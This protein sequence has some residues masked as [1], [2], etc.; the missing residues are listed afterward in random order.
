M[1]ATITCLRERG[2]RRN[3]HQI[4]SDPGTAGDLILAM[5]GG[6][7]ELKL[8][9]IDD[10]QQQ[11]PIIPSLY[12]ARLVSMHG[13]GMLFRGYERGSDGAGYVQEWRAVMLNG[14]GGG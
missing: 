2:K 3:D 8:A 10:S 9:D 5:V 7:Y 6:V 11:K 12:D 14:K 1:Y 13:N 4:D